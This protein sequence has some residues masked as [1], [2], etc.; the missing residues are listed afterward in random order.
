MYRPEDIQGRL[1]QKPFQ[2]F[3]IIA[4]EGLRYDIRHPDL[5]FVG[6]RDL[7][8]G[9]PAP[10]NPTIYDQV[11]RVALVHIVALEDLPAQPVAGDGQ[12]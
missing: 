7:M 10:D 11:T 3:R 9:S 12:K 1:R 8:I 4:S 6:A 2:P 5:V